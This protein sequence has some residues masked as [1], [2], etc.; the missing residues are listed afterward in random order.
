MGYIYE[1]KNKRKCPHCKKMIKFETD[2]DGI[3]E[4]IRTIKRFHK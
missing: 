4:R 2:H 3:D 1:Q